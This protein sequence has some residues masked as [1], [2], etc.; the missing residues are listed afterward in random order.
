MSSFTDELTLTYLPGP[1][2]WRTDR[3]FTYFVGTKIS[4]I[5]I[6]VP[7]GFVTDL[8]SVPWPASM[9]IPKSGRFNQS[10]VLHDF[11]YSKRGKVNNREYSRA[12]CDLIFL[13][14]MQVLGVH[15]FK[16]KIMYRAVRL[17]GWA[18]WNKKE[19]EKSK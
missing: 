18:A 13:E 7:K 5:K 11:L 1:N 3:Q 12:K 16:R 4:G 15:W 17:G 10:A 6:V 19:R 14:A 9:L 8:A 2:K